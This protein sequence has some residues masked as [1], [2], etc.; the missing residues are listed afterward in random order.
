MKEIVSTLTSKGQVTIPI[1]IRKQLG[2]A[3]GMRFAFVIDDDGNVSLRPPTYPTIA[4]LAGA[5]GKLPEPMT[6]DEM[7]RIAREDHVAEKYG[8]LDG[9]R[10]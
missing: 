1:E 6:W 2:L 10:S 9:D 3:T 4:S 7:R 8:G 5:A